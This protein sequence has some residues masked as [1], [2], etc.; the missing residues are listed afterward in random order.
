MMKRYK[1]YKAEK[2]WLTACIALLGIFA[3]GNVSANTS[4]QQTPI[5]TETTTRPNSNQSTTSDKLPANIN[6]YTPQT[7]S[8]GTVV[9]QNASGQV[10]NGWQT[11]QDDWYY[12]SDGQSKTNWQ[13][14]GNNWYYLNPQD[15]VMKTGLQTIDQSTYY[16]NDQ[17]NG[18]YGAMQ[19]GWQLIDNDWY[20]FA[21]N[22]AAQTGWQ[23]LDNNWYYFNPTTSI[24]QVGLQQINGRGY[25]LN[26]QH[27]GTYGA[28]QS[29]WQRINGKW[30]GFSGPNDG[31]ALTGWQLINNNWYYFNNDGEA[32]T[33]AQIINGHHYFFDSTNAWA[34]R[35]W[36]YLNN[37]WYY[38]DPV[39]AWQ[40]TGWQT[41]NNHRYY[42]DPTTGQMA[43]GV[44]TIDGHRYYFDPAAGNQL[45]GFVLDKTGKKLCYFDEN[46]GIMPESVDVN[47][48][49]VDLDQRT[50]QVPSSSLVTGLNQINHDHFL[51]NNGLFIHNSWQQLN[52]AW[53]YF[54][55]NGVA[56][57]G[58]Y[59][60]P[61][62]NWY[63]FNAAGQA[64]TGWQSIN[65]RWYLFDNNNANAYTG[66]F[67]SDYG[68]WY[69]FDPYNAW[70]DTDWQ[71]LNGTWYYFDP[72]NA[73]MDLNRTLNYNWQQ[74]MGEY[75]NS[76]S[77][78]IQLQR[79]G[80]EYATT[81]NPGL[82]Y[83]TASTVKVAVL[84]MLLHATNGNLN[85]TQQ[86]LATRMIRNSDNNAT[87]AILNNYLGGI[88]SLASIYRD[89]GMNNTTAASWW[90]MTLTVPTDQLKLLNMIYLDSSTAYFN[91]QSKDYI[92][93][94]M[95]TVSSSQQW[96]ISA[97]SS[98]YY[99]KNGWRPASDNGMWEVNSIGYIPN[100][101][102][103][104][105]IAVYTRNN[106]NFNWGVSYVEALAR[107]TR[108][109]IG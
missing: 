33:G 42:L 54:G 22:G 104:Y 13:Y 86:S 15:Y 63:Y 37:Y 12:F 17:H 72:T 20:H 71:F 46:S 76:S 95:G 52:G 78:A 11:Q 94:L 51:Y 18:T 55:V 1:M 57:T 2:L 60:S 82:R 96:G 41:I 81:N 50:G 47:G 6:G 98:S 87:T 106:R 101:R 102:N 69:Y 59:Q 29:G 85:A 99:L 9:W 79:N 92:K 66:W 108:K 7:S 48:Q 10:A 53:Y 61:A 32:R 77:I 64:E 39:N 5:Q 105:T 35:G 25:Y 19:T 62:G 27:D 21:D 31:A 8:D 70:A 23:W 73:W 89:L 49:T 103:S 100:G 84:A 88:M 68:N 36:Q 90:G 109:I 38:F 14:V 24:M 44:T 26:D 67:Q 4:E 45:K 56:Q 3:T 28:M 58:W 93:W 75:W 30:Y 80:A 43:V 83:E 74:V 65:G 16:F 107:I 34:L 40:L 91:Q 97:G